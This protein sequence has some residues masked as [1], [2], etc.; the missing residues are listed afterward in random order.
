MPKVGGEYTYIKTAYG[1]YISFIFGS[2]R[3]LASIFAAALAAVAFVLQF[4]Y[5]FSAISPQI[6]N[7]ILNEGW[8]ISLVLVV[9]MGLFEVRGVRQIGNIS[10]HSVHL[11]VRGLYCWRIHPGPRFSKPFPL[12]CRQESQ[13]SLQP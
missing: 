9:V 12:L 13:E 1:G 10:C 11:A 2:F 3:W 7:D 8:I 5:L 6:Q 4:S